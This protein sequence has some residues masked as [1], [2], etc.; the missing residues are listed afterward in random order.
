M[1]ACWTVAVGWRAAWGTR[2]P[3][4]PRRAACA[5]TP[6]AG[7]RRA[8]HMMP[9]AQHAQRAGPSQRPTHPCPSCA[10]A[11]AGSVLAAG[12]RGGGARGCKPRRGRRPAPAQFFLA[13]HACSLIFFGAAALSWPPPAYPTPPLL[14]RA[15]LALAPPPH[16]AFQPPGFHGTPCGS[17]CVPP[18]R[19]ALVAQSVT[20]PSL[21][22]MPPS[23]PP[24][25]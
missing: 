15:P 17:A 6:P 1:A 20:H 7:T 4:A 13:P 3:T 5:R 10:I 24:L 22:L 9:D 8:E 23:L 21:F 19:H 16:T 2:W 11:T 25:R 14:S 12:R 18:N